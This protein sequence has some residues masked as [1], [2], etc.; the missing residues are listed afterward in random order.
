MYVMYVNHNVYKPY[1]PYRIMNAKTSIQISQRLKKFLINNSTN[2]NQSYED[3]IWLLLGT[4]TLTK[5]QKDL[6]KSAYE[7][8]L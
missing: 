7:G 5:E 4:K 2:K 6:C 3:I 8:S 1:N